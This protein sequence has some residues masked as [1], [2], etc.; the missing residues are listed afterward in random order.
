MPS[1]LRNEAKSVAKIL[2]DDIWKGRI[3][4]VYKNSGK[5]KINAGK[6]VGIKKGMLLKVC[7]WGKKIKP[8]SAPPF[9]CL[10]KD[11]GKIKIVSVKDHYS[12]AVPLNKA[13]YKIGL[14]VIF[15]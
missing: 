6:D 5:I 7:A 11:I 13:D 2:E 8:P 10:G 14:P 3:M 15:D 4:E 12:I 1:L 9:Y